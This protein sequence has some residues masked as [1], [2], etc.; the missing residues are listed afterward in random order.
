LK[1]SDF[2]LHPEIIKAID[3]MGY[4]EAT[5]IQDSVIPHVLNGRDV[6]GL[7]QTGTEQVKQ[8]HL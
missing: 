2:D 6:A 1:F 7:A 5:P 3:K 8:L 4:T